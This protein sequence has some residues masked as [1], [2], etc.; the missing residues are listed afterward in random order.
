M[1]GVSQNHDGSPKRRL[2]PILLLDEP[3][4]SNQT[5]DHSR[6]FRRSIGSEAESIATAMS[7]EH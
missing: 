5:L 2:Q 1:P 7:I 6:L 3:L 4:G